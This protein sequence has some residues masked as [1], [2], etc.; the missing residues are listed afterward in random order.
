M[1]GLAFLSL[2]LSVA[3]VHIVPGALRASVLLELTLVAIL[4]PYLLYARRLRAHLQRLRQA[5]EQNAA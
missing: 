2:L 4:A 5:L 1:V 3:T